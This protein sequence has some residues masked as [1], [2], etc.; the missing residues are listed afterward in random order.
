VDLLAYL[1]ALRSAWC[2]STSELPDQWRPDRPST[3]QCAVSAM[4][5]RDRFGGSIVRGMTLGGTV[6]Y[7]NVINGVTIDATRD[8]FPAD[9]RFGQVDP[10]P[11]PELYDSPFT[12]GL[13]QRLE[14]RMQ[15]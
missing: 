11:A 1:A 7:W 2:H 8:Q 9:V 5:I 10:D 14:H 12:R 4:M 15:T 6:H 13:I 3:G